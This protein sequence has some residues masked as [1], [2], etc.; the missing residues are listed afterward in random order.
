MT[1]VGHVEQMHLSRCYQGSQTFSCLTC[2]DP[3]AEPPPLERESYY[4]AVCLQC[5]Q[6]ERCKVA[7]AV[8][9]QRSPSN[10]CLLCHMPAAATEIPHLA[11]THHR[12]GIHDLSRVGPS[13][14]KQSPVL[15]TLEPF[16]DLSRLSEIDRRRSLG[17]GYLEVAN[18]SKDAA[19][20][21]EYRG[22]ALD[23]MTAV[24]S[25]GLHDSALDTALARLRFDVG[26]DGVVPLAESAL[27]GDLLDPQDRCN[28]LFLVGEGLAHAG[29]N[30]EAI[31]KLRELVT[32]RRHSVQLL[33]LADCER[34]VGDPAYVQT[35]ESAVRINPRLWKMHAFLADHYR[36][37]G[38]SEKADYHQKRAVP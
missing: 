9:D 24:R 18:M 32:L 37:Q 12:I 21:D 27:A 16:F 17:L 29:R 33:L 15:T 7:P 8:R 5:H 4:R 2:H 14:D 6:P 31:P 30:A 28:A 13:S 36:R 11:F 10:N 1:V 3:H 35:L 34:A 22:R 20:A 38:D 23:L 25:E 26:L 19:L